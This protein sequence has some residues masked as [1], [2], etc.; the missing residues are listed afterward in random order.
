MMVASKVLMPQDAGHRFRI[1]GMVSPCGG[2][3]DSPKR[4]PKRQKI[5]KPEHGVETSYHPAVSGGRCG[6]GR[7]EPVLPGH[8]LGPI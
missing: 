2:D 6:A 4:Y 3:D 5:S 7:M 1:G 8:R